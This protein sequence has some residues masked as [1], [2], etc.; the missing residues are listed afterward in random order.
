[1]HGNSIPTDI[2]G[3]DVFE[4]INFQQ[5]YNIEARIARAQLL[6]KEYLET[7]PKGAEPRNEVDV[8]VQWLSSRPGCTDMDGPQ[9]RKAKSSDQLRIAENL[10]ALYSTAGVLLVDAQSHGIIAAKIAATE[11]VARMPNPPAFKEG[12]A[13]PCYRRG[14]DSVNRARYVSRVHAL[15]TRPERNSY[16]GAF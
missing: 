6:S 11:M 5:R 14:E 1:M 13:V 16:A 4:Y 9:Y 7:L 2:V 10:Q 8:N 15:R 12:S 3:G